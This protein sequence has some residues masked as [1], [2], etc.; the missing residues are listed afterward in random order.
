MRELARRASRAAAVVLLVAGAARAE[1]VVVDPR[2]EALRADERLAADAV[3]PGQRVALR[4][5]TPLGELELATPW[6]DFRGQ[7]IAAGRY[8]LRYALQPRL[9]DHVGV[10]A[11]R[12]F[13]LLVPAVEAAPD[14]EVGVA[15]WIAASRRVSAT[16]H[17]AVM[18]LLAWEGAEPPPTP[19]REDGGLSVEYLEVGGLVLGFVVAGEVEARD[20]F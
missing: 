16:A 12:D 7:S 1:S 20:A 17:P 18:A 11:I 3:E 19:R 5:G 10:D 6:R 9:K 15:A 2:R 13:A 8:G 4:D 14:P